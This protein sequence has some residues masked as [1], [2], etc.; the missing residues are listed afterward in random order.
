M[1]FLIALDLS[2]NETGYAVF[3]KSKRKKLIEWGTISNNHFDSNE[4]GK[5]LIRLEYMLQALKASYYTSEVVMEDWVPNSPSRKSSNQS[6]YKVGGTHSIAKKVWCN[7]EI[8]VVN[9][10]TAK[11]QFVGNGNASKEEVIEKVY[12]I[13]D[14]LVQKSLLDNFSVTNDN[15]ADAIMIGIC[16][17]QNSGEW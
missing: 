15:D 12:D 17:L 8:F 3:D 13:K 16:H 9:N 6:A 10:R 14:K 4:E 7:Q 1:R 2:L 5:K 11:K